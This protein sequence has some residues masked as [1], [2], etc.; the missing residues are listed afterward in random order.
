[1]IGLTNTLTHPNK[2]GYT[3]AEKETITS[4]EKKTKGEVYKTTEFDKTFFDVYSSE[5]Y[6]FLSTVSL[7]V[8]KV[9]DTRVETA[10]MASIKDEYGEYN[11]TIGFNPDFMRMHPPEHQQGIIVHE[12]YHLVFMHVT[13][14]NVLDKRMGS[15]W[16]VATD[17]A[18]N[19]L[20]G[21]QNLPD[22][23]LMPGKA[24]K[25]G[26]P[27]L[28]EFIKNAPKNQAADYYYEKMKEIV[29]KSGGSGGQCEGDGDGDGDATGGMETLDDHDKWG[30]IP[31]EIQEQ[32]NEKIRQMIEEASKNCDKTNRWGNIPQ[33]IREKIRELYSREVDWRSIL[34]NFIGRSR[35]SERS[36]SMKKINKRAMYKLPGAR[37]KT[38]ANF[39]CF[40]DQS[41][42]MGDEDIAMLFA[43]L[44]SLSKFVSID[45]YHFD[46]E[47]D[48]KSHKVWKKGQPAPAAYRTRSG[49]TDFNAIADMLNSRDYR[50]KWSGC[51]ILTDGYA[52]K[53]GQIFDTRVLWVITPGGTL[54]ATRP[55]DLAC[56]MKKGKGFE[57]T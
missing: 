14:R 40:I 33:E 31:A 39:A 10:Y 49:G 32:L 28:I 13:K 22:F 42:S 3:M 30:E 44:E 29:E 23:C 7:E 57:K 26:D 18:I 21:E 54:G 1:M 25:K 12:L 50:G 52:D 27:K 24:P 17:L 9:A 16:N 56:Q 36:A 11:F 34:R 5:Q 15:L 45:V 8:T 4:L 43:E 19:S 48:K 6:V 37:R 53:L 55:G 20:I 47:I 2:R 38:Y 46:T 35:S 41:G 51:I